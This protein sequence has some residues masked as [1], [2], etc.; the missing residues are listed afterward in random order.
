[1]YSCLF[2]TVITTW[3][4][5]DLKEV[6]LILS[7][8][9]GTHGGVE[10]SASTTKN[11]CKVK[12]VVSLLLK[13]WNVLRFAWKFNSCQCENKWNVLLMH[14]Q[15]NKDSCQPWQNYLYFE[16]FF[17]KFF[18]S[19]F[20]AKFLANKFWSSCRWRVSHPWNQLLCCTASDSFR[21]LPALGLG[22]GCSLQ[23]RKSTKQEG[24]GIP[25]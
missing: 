24:W 16:G 10:W 1:M 20:P 6:L 22:Q 2:A 5:A 19:S 4:Q 8:K 7:E 21:R 17:F 13:T 12:V 25:G 3:R 23:M 18:N 11:R 15:R 14:G 9:F